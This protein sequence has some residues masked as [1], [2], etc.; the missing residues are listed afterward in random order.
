MATGLQLH[1]HQPSL[2]TRRYV[3]GTSPATSCCGSL[4]PTYPDGVGF[5]FGNFNMC[6]PAE[7]RLNPQNQTFSHGD[8]SRAAALL[9]AFPRF[10]EIAQP[11]F[12]RKDVRRD[13][14]IHT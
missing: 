12:T 13:G 1:G 3:A 4:W 7:G 10:V 14:S 9:A 2:P 6:V 5:L 8:A 11:F